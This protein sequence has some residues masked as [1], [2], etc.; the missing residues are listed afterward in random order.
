MSN[1]KNRL[2]KLEAKQPKPPVKFDVQVVDEI[3]EAMRQEQREAWAR[4][5]HYYIIEPEED[6]DNEP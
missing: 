2:A 6:S 4:G 3:T 1:H 5:E